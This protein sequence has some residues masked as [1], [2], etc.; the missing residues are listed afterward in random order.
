MCSSTFVRINNVDKTVT[1]NLN[2][3]ANIMRLFATG[4]SH[5]QADKSRQVREIQM[6][7][8][9]GKDASRAS[10]S[11]S[12]NTQNTLAETQ[13]GQT[14]I[15]MQGTSADVAKHSI[16]WRNLSY[17]VAEPQLG[18]LARGQWPTRERHLIHKMS[19]QASAGDFIG[20]LGPSSAGKTTLLKALAGR[21]VGGQVSGQVL[22]NG[23]RRIGPEWLTQHAFIE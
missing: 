15:E 4:L 3:H 1:V 16:A 20:I 6:W 13:D 10:T 5:F 23:K 2:S 14:V 17:T 9:S 19:G 12:S 21:V 18:N 22:V 8:A 7:P 11:L